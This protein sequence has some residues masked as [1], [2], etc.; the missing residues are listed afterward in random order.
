MYNMTRRKNKAYILISWTIVI[1]WLVLIFY[2]SSQV[3]EKSNGLSKGITEVIVK[4]LEKIIP[5]ANIDINRFNH[6]LRKNAHFF[7]YFILGVL[8][9]N[10]VN[11]KGINGFK[12]FA[13]ALG[14]C[15]LY[16]ISDEVH[17]LFV[18]GR[19]A[20]VKDV[21]IDSAGAATGIGICKIISKIRRK[22]DK[23]L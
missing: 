5:N 13:I 22:K 9:M 16:A 23:I 10:I 2:L 11:R 8:V 14:I 15:I 19:G 4:T 1:L 17:Q 21:L 7:A 18:P 12:A 6:L 3:V 20:Q